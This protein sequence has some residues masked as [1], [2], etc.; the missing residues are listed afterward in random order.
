M[1]QERRAIFDEHAELY[2][3]ARPRYPAELIADVA[4]LAGIT[5][6]RRVAEI[7]PGTGQATLALA[8]LGAHMTAVEL[9]PA[10]ARVLQRTA[11]GRAIEVVVSAFEDW[12][13][14]ERKFDALAAFTS[15]HWLDPAL[16]TG[17]ATQLL[18]PGGTLATVTTS[19][20][21]GGSERFFADAQH[22]YE[23]WDPSTPVGLRLPSAASVGKA[24][25]EVDSSPLFAPPERRRFEQTIKYTATQYLDVLGTYSGHRA[26]EPARRAGLFRCLRELIEADHGGTIAKRYLHELRVARRRSEP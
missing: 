6:G 21:A 23:R 17:K 19:H 2:E 9:G 10:L 18:R 12:T 26:L 14:D 15:W 25:D 24:L 13:P 5:P 16:R 22:C 8:D 1:P 3:R 4:D 7:G 20:I 11:S